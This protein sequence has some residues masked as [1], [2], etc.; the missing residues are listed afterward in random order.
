M[1]NPV[2]AASKARFRC[3]SR[4]WSNCGKVENRPMARQDVR[5]MYRRRV[6]I[7]IAYNTVKSRLEELNAGGLVQRSREGRRPVTCRAVSILAGR[8]AG[9]GASESRRAGGHG[10]FGCHVRRGDSALGGSPA[11]TRSSGA[12]TRR[13]HARGSRSRQGRARAHR[14]RPRCRYSRAP[15]PRCV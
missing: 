2:W 12:P 9:R 1:V 14:C 3:R 8:A 11:P 6:G 5:D 10:G 4:A 13:A 7:P 15:R